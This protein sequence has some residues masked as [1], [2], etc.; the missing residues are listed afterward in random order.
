[1]NSEE[2]TLTALQQSIFPGIDV[3]NLRPI[4]WIQLLGWCSNPPGRH[5]LDHSKLWSVRNVKTIRLTHVTGSEIN[6]GVVRPR[7]TA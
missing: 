2:V 3:A 7:T 4:F 1:M 5:Q 6:T